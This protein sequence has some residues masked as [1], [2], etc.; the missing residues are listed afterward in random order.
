MLI[1]SSSYYKMFLHFLKVFAALQVALVKTASL[2]AQAEMED[3]DF[4]VHKDS[5]VHLVLQVKEVHRE[6]RYDVE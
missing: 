3:Q 2:V 6:H 5:Q 4:P 1:Y